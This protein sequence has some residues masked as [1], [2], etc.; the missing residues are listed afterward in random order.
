MGQPTLGGYRR[1]TTLCMPM[2]AC[3]IPVL[4]S[5]TKH[6]ITEV[7]AGASYVRPA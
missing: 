2:A 4:S 1:V 6:S 3:G 7:Q 5:E